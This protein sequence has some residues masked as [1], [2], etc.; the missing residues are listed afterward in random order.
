[1]RLCRSLLVRALL[2][3]AL[4][5]IARE[6]LAAQ[7]AEALARLEAARDAKPE[8]F[9]TQ[10]ALGVAYFKAE[11]YADATAPLQAARSLD[12]ADPVAALYAGLTADQLGDYSS[13]RTAYTDYLAVKR[14]WYAFKAKR[15]AAQVRDRLVAIAHLESVA[16]AKAAVAAEATLAPGGGDPRTIA[17]PPMRYSGPD[18][19]A[20]SPLERGLAELVI[21]DLGKSSQLVVVERDRM[22]ALADEIALGA[23][24][25]VDSASA[26]RA[27]RLIQAGRLVN[28]NIVHGGETLTL[29]SSI[30]SVRT[31]EISSPARVSDGMDK[32]FD[33]Q[34]DLVFQIFD[35]LGVVLTD[36]ERAAIGVRHT[37]N[38][39][40][41]LLYSSGLVAMDAGRF[42]D[43]ARL[44]EQAR[45][46][47]P[48]FAAAASRAGL[49][50]AAMVGAA[51]NATTLES[52]MPVSERNVVSTAVQGVVLPPAPPALIPGLP[53]IPRL[54]AAPAGP[55]GATLAATSL[56]VNPP[57]V[58]PVTFAAAPGSPPTP[59]FDLPSNVS[60]QDR[61]RIVSSILVFVRV[62]P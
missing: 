9:S 25:A 28:G 11:R 33:L 58:S 62:L 27:G 31:S 5:A 50:Q 39:E 30:V 6:P 10:R 54:P 26:V 41:F 45:V 51:V 29:T 20:L 22:Q 8:D 40:A 55:L 35:Q 14:P 47:D 12:A 34:K 48:S 21:T 19:A 49:A 1:M 4:L 61:L 37:Q 17:V 24:G 42:Q 16:A 53:G 32:F 46:A 56:G 52:A 18:A 59:I 36:E 60:G 38:F 57:S 2:A 43:A 13:A 44:F 23:S 15:A 7:S 3:V